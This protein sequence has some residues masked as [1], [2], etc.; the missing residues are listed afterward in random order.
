MTGIIIDLSK[1]QLSFAATD[2]QE[3]LVWPVS[4]A[5]NGGGEK[6]DSLCTPRGHHVITERIGSGCEPNTVFTGRRPTGEIYTPD[7]G[8]EHPGRDWILTRI[9][10]L[11]G[12]EDGMNRGGD[13]DTKARYIYIHG[14]PD[15]TRL[16][17]PGSRGCIR[18]S[19]RDIIT[20]YDLVE[21]GTPV[22]I[23]EGMNKAG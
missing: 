15:E 16:G 12:L 22:W 1:Q 13:C 21:V 11:Q 23:T 14:T 19:N 9:L 8:R 5:R 10:W 20:L 18:M 7:L 4:T 17:V 2:E 6:T 3:P